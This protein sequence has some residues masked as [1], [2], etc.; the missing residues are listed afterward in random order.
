MLSEVA[1]FYFMAE[2]LKYYRIAIVLPAV[3]Q[4]AETF[5]PNTK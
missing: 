5:F 2:L 4:F 1:S 3:L